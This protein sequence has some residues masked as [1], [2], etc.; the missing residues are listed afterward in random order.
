MAIQQIDWLRP[1]VAAFDF[2]VFFASSSPSTTVARSTT[3][4]VH[5]ITT[6]N[7]NIIQKKT[8]GPR[9]STGDTA[10]MIVAVARSA[11]RMTFVFP[12]ASTTNPI[13]GLNDHAR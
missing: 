3:T 13:T 7:A 9:S 11:T 5:A 10:N 2:P 1:T 4:S 6:A 12:I 8:V